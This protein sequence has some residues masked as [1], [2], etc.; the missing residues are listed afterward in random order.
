MLQS[1][2]KNIISCDSDM[3]FL[4]IYVVINKLS[5]VII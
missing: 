2:S 5:R 1:Y 4:F 3:I